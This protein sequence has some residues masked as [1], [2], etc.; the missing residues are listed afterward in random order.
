MPC[1]KYNHPLTVYRQLCKQYVR[2]RWF[3][4]TLEA[5]TSLRRTVTTCAYECLPKD[6]A[7]KELTV[8][9]IKVE[10]SSNELLLAI[11][12]FIY[13]INKLISKLLFC[14]KLH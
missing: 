2:F 5:D 14:Q 3:L 8:R 4:I 12:Q 1:C 9:R 13:D 6:R 7:K 10:P 11:N